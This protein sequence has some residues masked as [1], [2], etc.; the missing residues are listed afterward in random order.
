[1]QE[2]GNLEIHIMRLLIL[3]LKDLQ[4]FVLELESL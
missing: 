4:L 3:L 2:G 1:M